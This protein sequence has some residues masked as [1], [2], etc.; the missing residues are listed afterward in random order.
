MRS[1]L[2]A[3]AIALA[4]CGDSPEA[5]LGGGGSTSGG[6]NTTG[7]TNQG[8]GT[9]PNSEGGYDFC[10]WRAFSPSA[11]PSADF[12]GD[13]LAFTY[14][15]DMGNH[16]IMRFFNDGTYWRFG[17]GESCDT[18]AQCVAQ[19]A[20]LC[21]GTR[22]S[23]SWSAAAGVLTLDGEAWPITMDGDSDILLGTPPYT[24]SLRAATCAHECITDPTGD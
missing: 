10:P 12:V 14:D 18:E 19:A 24:I 17:F 8:D 4:G 15:T 1:L 21:E 13:W 23:G 3:I 20:E 6:S 5:S 22:G 7:G 11:D 9:V 2:F 16:A